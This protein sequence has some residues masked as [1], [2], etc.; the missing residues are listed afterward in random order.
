[1][2]MLNKTRLKPSIWLVLFGYVHMQ[3]K[4]GISA[5]EPKRGP[6]SQTE[7]EDLKDITSNTAINLG[8]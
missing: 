5:G 8:L 7:R 2:M 1:M 3:N 4:L 6:S